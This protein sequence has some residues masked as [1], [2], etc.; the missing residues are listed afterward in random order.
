[1]VV[2]SCDPVAILQAGKRVFDPVAQAAEVG[3]VRDRGLPTDAGGDA[4]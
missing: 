1:M 3:V 4:Q 2:S